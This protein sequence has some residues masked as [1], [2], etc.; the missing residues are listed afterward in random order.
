MAVDSIKA[1]IAS[2]SFSLGLALSRVSLINLGIVSP[3][4]LASKA[5]IEPNVRKGKYLLL[6]KKSLLVAYCLKDCAALSKG[7]VAL[8]TRFQA[9][10]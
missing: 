7:A 1:F 10:S 5:A 2:P 3:T 4:A 6:R 8:P 9:F